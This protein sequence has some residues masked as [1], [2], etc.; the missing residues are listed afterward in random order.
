MAKIIAYVDGAASNN[1]LALERVGGWAY[2]LMLQKENGELDE[3]PEAYKELSGR[4]A[5]A[6][7][8]QMELEAVRQVLL[9]L[10]R[11][12]LKI[13]I[14]SDSAYV[15][16]ILSMNWK[17]KENKGLVAEIKELIAKHTVTFEKVAGHTGHKHNERADELAVAATKGK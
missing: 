4:V 2:V 14:V 5:G 3:R 8:N 7:N 1:Q 12:G 6:T 13:V 11:D 16:G 17:V 15:I 9:S 10:K